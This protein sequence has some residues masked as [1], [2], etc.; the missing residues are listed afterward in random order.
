[1]VTDFRNSIRRAWAGFLAAMLVGVMG[2]ACSGCG[3]LGKGKGQTDD[4]FGD[5]TA[6]SK[7]VSTKPA[8]DHT[9]VGEVVYISPD[10]GFVLIK[11]SYASRIST[12]TEM[13]GRTSEGAEA[14][15]LRCSPERK[16]SFI[17]ADILSGSPKVGYAVYAPK[18]SIESMASGNLS[19]PGRGGNPARPG[20]RV[21]VA[22]GSESPGPLDDLPPLP[23]LNSGD[24]VDSLPEMELD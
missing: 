14:C 12:G 16:R 5:D 19:I 6:Q 3:V 8:K 17:V 1:M 15:T 13:R 10:L 20:V 4:N 7:Q 23:D 18:S 2:L 24:S 22:P 21:P 9:K 11:S